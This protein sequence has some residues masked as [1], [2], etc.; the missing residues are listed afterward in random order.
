[1]HKP[2]LE[3]LKD[4]Q[5][6]SLKELKQKMSEHFHLDDLALAEPLSDDLLI[7]LTIYINI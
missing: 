2:I 5:L 6:H 4:G 7:A 1:M 3:F